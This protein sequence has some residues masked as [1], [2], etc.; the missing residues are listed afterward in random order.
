VTNRETDGRTHDDSIYGASI[1]SRCKS[2]STPPILLLTQI[3][4]LVYYTIIFIR[5]ECVRGVYNANTVGPMGLKNGF[6]AVG[7]NSAESEL[8]WMK[9]EIM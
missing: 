6:H 5:L 4:L 9:S 1:A 3:I 8:I 2:Y 7:Y